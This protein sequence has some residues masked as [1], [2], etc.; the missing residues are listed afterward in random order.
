MEPLN[1]VAQEL[2]FQLE[3]NKA[4]T[5]DH[6][7]TRKDITDIFICTKKNGEITFEQKERGFVAAIKRWCSS[8]FLGKN[9]DLIENLSK[10]KTDFKSVE[11]TKDLQELAT[12][13]DKIRMHAI[14]KLE[15]KPH[16]TKE[17]NERIAA[18]NK[19][20]F[21]T[22]ASSSVQVKTHKPK[23]SPIATDRMQQVS[24][25][26]F[27]KT[28]ADA[29]SLVSV[30]MLDSINEG[31]VET[32]TKQ[33][34]DTSS[35]NPEVLQIKKVCVSTLNL[36][37]QVQGENKKIQQVEAT[38]SELPVEELAHSYNIVTSSVVAMQQQVEKFVPSM[39]ALPVSE[40]SAHDVQVITQGVS[41]LLVNTAD[42]IQNGQEV[43]A[44]V[45]NK[46]Y[47][48]NDVTPL[49]TAV[50][51]ESS[52]LEDLSGALSDFQK[53]L[54]T[55]VQAGAD[56]RKVKTKDTEAGRVGTRRAVSLSQKESQRLTEDVADKVQKRASINGLVASWK[57]VVR[58][59]QNMSS[60][61]QQLTNHPLVA[62]TATQLEQEL[63]AA[64][65]VINESKETLHTE[66]LA[67]LEE[68]PKL[69]IQVVNAPQ[70]EFEGS[71]ITDQTRVIGGLVEQ[72]PEDTLEAVKEQLVSFDEVED[73]V[74]LTEQLDEA[75]KSTLKTMH[76]FN[77]IVRHAPA[78]LEAVAPA[79]LMSAYHIIE[80]K[81][82][83][84][85]VTYT[86]AGLISSFASR[87]VSYAAAEVAPAGYGSV[88]QPAVEQLLGIAIYSGL[89]NQMAAKSFSD[90]TPE[91]TNTTSQMRSAEGM[92]PAN[93]TLADKFPTSPNPAYMPDSTF[94]TAANANT[95]NNVS[96]D[97]IQTHQ[98]ITLAN[99]TR[100][101]VLPEQTSP[102][103]NYTPN[104]QEQAEAPAISMPQA[105]NSQ[106]ST[107]ANATRPQELTSPIQEVP[108]EAVSPEVE[109]I[110]TAQ[111]TESIWGNFVKGFGEAFFVDKKAKLKEKGL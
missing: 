36:F 43:R 103:P 39:M 84:E 31:A 81:S 34:E 64:S 42:K 91:A 13:L 47:K 17:I 97:V 102:N 111:K 61:A 1:K 28:V 71:K 12:K 49:D 59:E 65:Q 72:L 73:A 109:V 35:D 2:K 24:K 85:A 48:N 6:K 58:Y 56:A 21:S 11:P 88:V 105:S 76:A 40:E 80:G 77:S 63:I 108:Q 107:P 3:P 5:K 86:A 92:S 38:Y 82:I 78:V 104:I 89:L 100:P 7:E 53:E 79:V 27:S 19:I 74:D 50:L 33:L 90:I 70:T 55:A 22:K 95:F 18:L 94:A 83:A 4:P 51:E 30:S 52:T 14:E 16:K 44:Q 41:K 101:D 99:V 26:A 10:L 9:Y 20:S 8:I 45:A 66:A 93:A 87:F 32:A 37:T 29:M 25:D 23:S 46:L 60:V 54:K 106:V 67:R 15:A 75:T 96:P 69:D 110:E 57:D 62:Q 68:T 98:P